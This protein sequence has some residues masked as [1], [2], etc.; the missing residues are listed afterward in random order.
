MSRAPRPMNLF[1]Y[2]DKSAGVTQGIFPFLKLSGSVVGGVPP[3]ITSAM[4]PMVVHSHEVGI[5]HLVEIL[6]TLS[7]SNPV[8]AILRSPLLTNIASLGQETTL[9]GDPD[10]MRDSYGFQIIFLTILKASILKKNDRLAADYR[11]TYFYPHA[12]LVPLDRTACLF[13]V[14]P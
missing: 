8:F 11:H 14:V 5:F 10:V 4:Y 6:L 12:R 7:H 2:L 1:V 13:L 3:P 9:P